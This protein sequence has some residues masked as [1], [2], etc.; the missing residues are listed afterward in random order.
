MPQNGCGER[1]ERSGESVR[2]A[3][4]AFSGM[5]AHFWR[6]HLALAKRELVGEI[7]AHLHHF[8]LELTGLPFIILGYLLAWIALAVLLS[9]RLP[10]WVAFGVGAVFNLLLGLLLLLLGRRKPHA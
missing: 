3:F 10:L 4:R 7:K 1:E 6:D 9:E 2:R 5:L 8:V